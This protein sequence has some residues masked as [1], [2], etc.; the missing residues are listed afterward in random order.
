[1]EYFTIENLV[2]ALF[3]AVL[4][5]IV[6][7]WLMQRSLSELAGRILD[8]KA[9]SRENALTLDELGYKKGVKA[10]LAGFFAKNGNYIAKAIVKVEE[11]ASEKDSELLFNT[12]APVKYCIPEENNNKRLAKHINDSMSLPKLI[13]VI[14]MLIV[15]AVAAGTV[16]DLLGK[17]ASNLTE[18]DGNNPVGVTDDETTL[19]EEQEQANKEEELE[20]KKQEELERLEE[21]A[22]KELEEAMKAEEQKNEGASENTE[23]VSED[24]AVYAE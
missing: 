13:A 17:Y 8:A 1:M 24:S 18:Y 5:A 4:A 10:F 20:K 2:W 15:I 16:I 19:L 21:Q 7:S 14:V 9:D 12:K 3:L 11:E 23:D 6:Y 22:K